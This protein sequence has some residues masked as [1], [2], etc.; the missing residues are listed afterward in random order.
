MGIFIAQLFQ[1][2]EDKMG[3]QEL[4]ILMSVPIV[5]AAIVLV[6]SRM[7]EQRGMS[8]LIKWLAVFPLIAGVLLGVTPYRSAHD[9]LYL[10]Y[11]RASTNS[12]MLHEAT[13]YAPSVA[14]LV[15]IAFLIYLDRRHRLE[16]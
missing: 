10:D 3:A 7:L 14:L 4:I 11:T 1:V 12:R 6:V 9:S 8:R 15:V 5:I 2:S 13:L 16:H